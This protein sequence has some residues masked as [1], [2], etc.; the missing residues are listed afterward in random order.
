MRRARH[1]QPLQAK[2]SSC[3]GQESH[4][5]CPLLS[6]WSPLQSSRTRCLLSFPGSTDPPRLPTQA[7][8]LEGICVHRS[9]NTRK[10]GGEWG[11]LSQQSPP[12]AG[13]QSGVPPCCV[14]APFITA[15]P[16]DTGWGGCRQPCNRLNGC[17]V[18]DEV[19]IWSAEPA[20]RP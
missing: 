16:G 15:G 2:V 10:R 18:E 5:L 9:A 17:R 14:P 11:P 8:G 3:P 1:G 19:V 6:H 7:W 13:L 20:A 4:G 12:R